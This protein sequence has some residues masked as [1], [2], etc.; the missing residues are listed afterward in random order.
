MNLNAARIFV[1]DLAPAVAFYADILGL[2]QTA[3]SAA[4]GYCVFDAGAVR[5]I[6]EAVAADACAQDAALVGRFT[7]LSFEV[8]D[9]RATHARLSSRGVPFDEEPEVQ[10]WGGVVAALRDPAGNVM[11]VCQYPVRPAT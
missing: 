8:D 6:V 2:R 10:A 7:G 1:R 4:A 3:G 5:L 9:V 11:Q